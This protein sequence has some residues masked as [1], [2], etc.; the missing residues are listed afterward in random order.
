L[1]KEGNGAFGPVFRRYFGS[2]RQFVVRD[3]DPLSWSRL[4]SPSRLVLDAGSVDAQNDVAHF[5]DDL[6]D[7]ERCFG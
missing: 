7:G 6:E 4:G 3:D 2:E 5:I 1:A